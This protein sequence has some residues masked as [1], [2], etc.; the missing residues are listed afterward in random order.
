MSGEVKSVA[1]K[2]TELESELEQYEEK[3]GLTIQPRISKYLNVTHEEMQK[4]SV[5]ELEEAAFDVANYGIY[6]QKE[7]N[8]HTS[9]IGWAT[10]NMNPIIAREC[11]NVKGYSYEERKLAIIHNNEHTIKLEGIR[12]KSQLCYDRLNF[13]NRRIDF[14]SEKF[15]KLHDSKQ[16][17]NKYG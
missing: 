13:M 9:R 15:S 4:M 7:M 12:V 8:K 14:L 11:N 2:L 10:S 16:R 17:R 3:I 6:L 5:E 1:A